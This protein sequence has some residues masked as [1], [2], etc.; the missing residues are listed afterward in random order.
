MF[1]KLRHFVKSLTSKFEHTEEPK[2]NE[3]KLKI[4]KEVQKP[5]LEFFMQTSIPRRKIKNLQ[6]NQKLEIE[7]EQ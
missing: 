3:K 7:T 6:N 4:P 1:S 5:M 2:T